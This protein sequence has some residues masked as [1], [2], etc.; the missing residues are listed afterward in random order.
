MY[1]FIVAHC[2]RLFWISA[3]H[4]TNKA[5]EMHNNLLLKAFCEKG[6]SRLL[7]SLCTASPSHVVSPTTEN[8]TTVLRFFFLSFSKNNTSSL[9]SGLDYVAAGISLLKT[10]FEPKTIN[11]VEVHS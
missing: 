3:Y 5:N 1:F 4:A 6:S 11:K 8:K 7:V 2:G 9:C 10:P